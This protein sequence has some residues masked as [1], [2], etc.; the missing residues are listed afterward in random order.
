MS[1]WENSLYSYIEGRLAPLERA[2]GCYFFRSNSF[3]GRIQR[4]NGT[5]GFVK[6]GKPG[7]PDVVACFYSEAHNDIGN[8]FR[9]YGQF[10]GFELKTEK[11][12][13]SPEQ[14]LAQAS[15]ESAGGLYYL[16]RSPEMFESILKELIGN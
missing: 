3:T 5:T 11:G 13:Q 7:M 15:I 2:G 16:I 12:R 8:Y 6:N 4:Y 10:V 9:Q 14:K 1:V